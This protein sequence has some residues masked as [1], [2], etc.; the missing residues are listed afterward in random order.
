VDIGQKS[1]KPYRP[2]NVNT[3]TINSQR[4]TPKFSIDLIHNSLV[5]SMFQNV[6]LKKYSNNFLNINV[7][8][9]QSVIWIVPI[10]TRKLIVKS[11]LKVIIY[12]W[13]LS[14]LT[15]IKW[16][17]WLFSA[18]HCVNT[19]FHYWLEDAQRKTMSVVRCF[20]SD[21]RLY[22]LEVEVITLITACHCNAL[23]MISKNTC[24]EFPQPGDWLTVGW[25]WLLP[26]GPVCGGLGLSRMRSSPLFTVM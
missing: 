18:L 13:S 10:R 7:D 3:R 11:N 4:Q 19:S 21:G 12:V 20:L 8:F 5:I 15:R 1:C 24:L 22:Y 26:I 2:M 9:W 25:F 6:T 23:E 17:E 14:I 16:N